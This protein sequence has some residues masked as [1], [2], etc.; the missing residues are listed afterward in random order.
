MRNRLKLRSDPSD[1][2]LLAD[3]HQGLPG[4]KSPAERLPGEDPLCRNAGG[5]LSHLANTLSLGGGASSAD[6]ALDLVLNEIAEKARLATAASGV[7]VALTRSGE[8]V[9]RAT[10]GSAPDLGM[11]LPG[12]GL[13]GLSLRTRTVQHCDDAET[14]SRV[15]AVACRN[16]RVRSILVIPVLKREEAVG[17]LE[18]FSADP[19]HF[20]DHDIEILKSFCQ[21]IVNNLDHA[22]AVAALPVLRPSS[23]EPNA[24]AV[25]VEPPSLQPSKAKP[26]SWDRWG[27]LLTAAVVAVA[28]LLGWL[29]GRAGKYR[30]GVIMAAHS[31]STT[32]AQRSHNTISHQIAPA[33]EK[34]E[35][36][37]AT[38][39]VTHPGGPIAIPRTHSESAL[40]KTTASGVTESRNSS[41]G[42]LD[43]GLVVS[44]NGKVLF[45][46]PPRSRLEPDK[47]NVVP[48][49][50]DPGG[51]IPA[52]RTELLTPETANEYL[53]F[54]VAPQY[55]E[56]ARQAHVQGP[57]VLRVMV[58]K[59]GGV[60]QVH[61]LSGDPRLATAAANALVQ[62]RFR[63]LSRMGQPVEFETE[64]TVDFRLP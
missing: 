64:I 8:L 50:L 59:D 15:D 26:R 43:G 24:D 2:S 11:R 41:T 28:L 44:Q 16:L 58:G 63:P 29:L 49:K 32:G 13:S 46:E 54:R 30:A 31:V 21:Q 37:D 1:Y 6:L 17:L 57:V 10:T 52:S 61:V 48:K 20:R 22:A 19:Y 4:K 40:A 12:G 39:G 36:K 33:G 3:V 51:V 5:S 62:W 14:D 25:S 27:V 47:E 23:V 38:T 42:N 55:P 35:T 56:V 7:A 34:I 60:Q 53:T 45:R 9:C 18:A